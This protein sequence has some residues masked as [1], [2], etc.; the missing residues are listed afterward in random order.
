MQL[1]HVLQKWTVLAALSFMTASAFADGVVAELAGTITAK[2][3]GDVV[4]LG[5]GSKVLEGDTIT[6]EKGAYA[7]IKFSDGMIMTLKPG[8]QVKIHDQKF[9]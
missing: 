2:R 5:R 3:G 1:T 9:S 7:Q 8:T 4:S 6:T